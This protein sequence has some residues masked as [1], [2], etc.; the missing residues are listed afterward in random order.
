MNTY[1]QTKYGIIDEAS[2]CEFYEDG[3]IKECTLNAFNQ[4][5]TNYGILTAQFDDG[6]PR[7]KFTKSI[8]F[9]KSGAL[10]SIALSDQTVIKT[11]A[12]T[13]PAELLVFYESGAIKRLFPLNGKI[14]GYWSE[15]DEYNIAPVLSL[16][17]GSGPITT[18]VISVYFYESGEI[19]GLTLWPKDHIK[20]PIPLGKTATTRIGLTFYPDGSIKSFEPNIPIGV[21]TPIGKLEAFNISAIG[22]HGDLNSLKFNSNG[23]ISSL[24]TST[25]KVTVI[26]PDGN[27]IP[28]EPR[29]V[30]NPLILGKMGLSPLIIE[31]NENFVK[32]NNEFK[33]ELDKYSFTI[34]QS[35]AIYSAH[36]CGDCSACDSYSSCGLV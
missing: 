10:K 35:T 12:G 14:T 24:M 29:L 17:L 33:Y 23:S 27:E 36:S 32:F 13:F 26:T 21:T 6:K 2:N 19:K 31:F 15:D 4:I 25:D 16:N 34:S 18:K 9:Y 7:K 22:I 20:V 28:Y 8:S 30:P 3:S 1:L 11:P 5:P